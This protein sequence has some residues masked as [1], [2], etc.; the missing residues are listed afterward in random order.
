MK[1][2]LK[3]AFNILDGRLSTSIDDVY[4][5]LDFIFNT[6]LFTHQLPGAMNVL[7]EKNPKWFSDGVR[8][9]D[10]IKRKH[11]TDDF[12]FLMDIIDKEYSQEEII[13]EKL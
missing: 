13:I 5:M 7:K 11:D 8:L 10:E 6:N 1:V 9:L 12:V 3:K 4:E 2:P